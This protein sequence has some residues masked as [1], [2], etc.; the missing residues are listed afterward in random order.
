[1]WPVPD[2]LSSFFFSSR[3]FCWGGFSFV[4]LVQNEYDFLSE[5]SCKMSAR[6]KRAILP[7]LSRF[8]RRQIYVELYS[9]IRFIG[10]DQC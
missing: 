1:M 2:F 3:G 5:V 7:S 10:V 6:K 8:F 9:L 4:N